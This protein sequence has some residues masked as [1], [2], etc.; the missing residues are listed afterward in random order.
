MLAA[1]PT[2]AGINGPNT[3]SIIPTSQTPVTQAPSE[4]A[5]LSSEGAKQQI[6]DGSTRLAALGQKGTTVGQNGSVTYADGSAVPAPTGAE[7]DPETGTYK[8]LDG[9]TY[10]AAEFY[11][12]GGNAPDD[13]FTA[14][15]KLFDPLKANLDAN[16][17]SQVNA[18][19]QQFE[20]LKSMQTDA[21]T[22]A[23][24]AGNNALML[25]GNTR[26]SPLSAAGI[27]LS[28]T[29]NG[30][31]AIASL[32][33]K[34]NSAIAS[35]QAAQQSG[36][37]DLM[38]KQIDTAETIRK[39]KQDTATSIQDAIQKANG[40][41]QTQRTQ[42]QQSD[43]V[44]AAMAKGLTN[45]A[46]ILKAVNG[47]GYN[48]TADDVA[49]FTKDLT[50][51]TAEGET[52]KFSNADVGTMLASGLN[53]AQIQAI[54]DYYN[55]KTTTAPT[56]TDKQNAAVQKALTGV[57]PKSVTEAIPANGVVTSGNLVASKTDIDAGTQALMASH[58]P[59]GSFYDVPSKFADPNLYLQMY[60]HWRNQGGKE[61]DFFKYYPYDTYINPVNTWLTT[62]IDNF[63][64]S[65]SST[66]SGGG[67]QEP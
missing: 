21:N 7:Y 17:L 50:P 43:A 65:D 12:Q 54:Q 35:A 36:D 62:A 20:T 38:L 67:G 23:S 6:D 25:S 31:N 61:E 41:L 15:S 45:P 42:Q 22:A 48:V 47:A 44:A 30:L 63:N 59:T 49:K 5:V 46:D 3:G 37:M 14:V 16:T 28:R 11:G 33:A 10:S 18:I 55:G 60:E 8:A 52:Y 56:L 4:P 39:Q 58:E 64:S 13:D 2:F 32:D 24:K 66:S 53:G 9:K 34:E 57:T 40:D 19:Q 1:A 26:Y 29:T 27:A 51:T